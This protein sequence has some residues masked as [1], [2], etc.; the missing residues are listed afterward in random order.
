[1]ELVRRGSQP[2]QNKEGPFEVVKGRSL[3]TRWFTCVLQNQTAVPRSWLLYSTAKKSAFFVVSFLKPMNM[4]SMVVLV[5][6]VDFAR[7]ESLIPVCMNTNAVYNVEEHLFSGK[8]WNSDCVRIR[9]LMQDYK[10]RWKQ[11]D[12]AGKM[13]SIGFCMR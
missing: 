4:I 11:K 5:L 6:W 7:G 8:S 9:L 13:Y 2:L 10:H 3:N 12:C 1:V